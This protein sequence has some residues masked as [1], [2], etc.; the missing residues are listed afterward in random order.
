MK[1]RNNPVRVAIIGSGLAG[2]T[3]AHILSSTFDKATKSKT[4]NVTI[5][6]KA[7][8]IGM[9]SGSITVPCLCSACSSNPSSEFL[10]LTEKERRIDVPMRGFYPDLYTG[11]VSLY[12]YL[13]IPYEVV[14]AGCSF[15]V[16][17]NNKIEPAFIT[18]TI[19]ILGHEVF[20]PTP[21]FLPSIVGT[22]RTLLQLLFNPFR[23]I[24]TLFRLPVAILRTLRNILSI[25]R[26]L[27]SWYRFQKTAT[28][29]RSSG[30]LV[31]VKGT[32]EEYL[33]REGY[34]KTFN[35]NVFLPALASL[36]T[37]SV[38]DVRQVPAR[39]VLG[40]L[41]WRGREAIS[42]TDTDLTACW[43]QTSTPLDH[44]PTLC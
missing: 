15:S 43:L 35:E 36:F 17:R 13:N 16:R 5:Y 18:G 27:Y 10:H 22:L 21:P 26:L 29:L 2:L 11:L 1:E 30:Q 8:A 23:L 25:L 38:D 12:D 9:D 42:E 3:T 39:V 32:T 28:F 24:G 44:V 33:S 37:C 6:E 40:E 19:R 41:R 14:G 31:E 4:F 34:D 7:N 20:F